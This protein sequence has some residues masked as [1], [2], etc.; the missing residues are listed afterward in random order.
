MAVRDGCG[1]GS[2]SD[3]GLPFFM[4]LMVAVRVVVKIFLQNNLQ[5]NVCQVLVLIRRVVFRNYVL[6]NIN[7]ID[8]MNGMV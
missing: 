6:F 7:A 2:Q 3:C 1:S 4:T 5:L 8:Q